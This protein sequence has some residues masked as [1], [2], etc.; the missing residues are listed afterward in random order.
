MS[1][2][3]ENK[4][5]GSLTK[6]Q[7]IEAL[8]NVANHLLDVKEECEIYEILSETINKILPG[9]I[10]VINKL[11]PEDMNFRIMKSSGLDKYLNKISKIL[12]IDLY[13]F[14]V[15]FKD[16]TNEQVQDFERRKMHHFQEG[17]YDLLNG[18]LNKIVCKAIEKLVGI[19]HVCSMSLCV[20]KKYFG[21]IT[22]FLSPS[23]LKSGAFNNDVE[24]VIE[25]IGNQASSVFQR[26]RDHANLKHKEDVLSFINH[27]IET[28]IENSSSGYLFEDI[29]RKILRVNKAF[30]KMFNIQN[31]DSI[32]GMDCKI[33]GQMSAS[34]FEDP[35][36]FVN[37]NDKFIHEKKPIF[38][39]ELTM[40]DGRILERDF[41]PIITNTLKGYLW[42][43]RDI[44]TRK[45][46][47]EQLLIKDFALEATPI[48]VGLADINGLLFY[49]NK[50]YLKLWGY[51]NLNEIIGKHI[52]EFA[53]S[54]EIVNEVIA[55]LKNGKSYSGEVQPTRKD[56]KKFNSLIS[57]CI[58]KSPEGRPICQMA[59][60]VDITEQKQI[61]LTLSEQ[62]AKLK[63]LNST[64]DKF[65]SIIAHD[66]KSPFS[67]ILGFTDLLSTKYYELTDDK[68]LHFINSLR[69]SANGA[70]KFLENLLDWARLQR[71]LIEIHKEKIFLRQLVID[72]IEPY[73][74]NAL[75]KEIK[76]V[77]SISEDISIFADYYS[78]KTVIGNLFN[79]SLKYTSEGGL[80]QF[81]AF[82]VGNNI[83][84]CVK[85]TGI[86]MSQEQ[87]KK[88]FH[89]EESKSMPG[90][91]DEKGTGLGLIICKE[92]IAKNDGKI[93]VES[94]LEKGSLFKFSLQSV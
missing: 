15:P 70:Y 68:R 35:E 73:L 29:S 16:F 87:V 63:E 42:Q 9:S 66:L 93:W 2:N 60:F 21:S 64:K 11:Q 6:Q 77:N 50:A 65:F 59:L 79:N 91:N 25:T 17:L 1:T 4:I 13:K 7:I 40:V 20:E 58:V 80:V 61:E 38:N 78:I 36:N 44:T 85:D 3:I 88:L 54:K 34:L 57:A 62:T 71:G 67:S 75:L 27:E 24:F 46:Y 48:S 43:Y 51:N 14:D 94:E 84:I 5:D 86:G 18:S 22:F 52:S 39:Q 23:I 53:N 12:G 10:F 74:P 49:A 28:L 37:D 47:E 90:T 83:E 69:I 76:T 41:V 72:S 8:H 31:S 26:L 89:I 45:K 30:C 81:D 19:A 92:F 56:G 55:T 32:I 33:A 82:I